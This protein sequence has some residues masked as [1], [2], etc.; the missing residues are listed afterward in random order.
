M[1][2]LLSTGLISAILVLLLLAS[3]IVMVTGCEK[4][5]ETTGKI[6]VVVTILP[7]AEFTEQ[8]GGNRVEVTVMVP[9]GASPHTYE[10][11]PSQMKALVEANLYVKVGSG[12]DFEL[13]WM[14]KLIATNDT[15]LIVDCSQG[16]TFQGVTALGEGND[17]HGDLDPHIWTSP[18]NAAIMV[19]NIA[20]S[21]IQIDSNNRNYYEQN[22]D[23]YLQKLEQLDNDIRYVLGGFQG[24]TFMIYH[25]AFGYFASEYGLT[26]LPIEADGKE[27]TVAGLQ[28][29]IEQA[30]RHN[31]TVVFA[32]S[33][34]STQ[35]AEV[36]AGEIGGQVILI[37][38]LA[39][40]YLTN[41]RIMVEKLVMTME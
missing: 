1:K 29:L 36:I 32:E 11:V 20:D 24:D 37:N 35:S 39:R 41:M 30:R 9:P 2:V 22:R 26:Q 4:T 12:V 19:R 34:Y 23:A 21:L 10:P 38:P 31:I 3:L 33:Q 15:M 7:Q 27:P 5:T 13:V 14:D 17:K 16:I 18:P 25:S 6:G 28:R 40:D 8:V